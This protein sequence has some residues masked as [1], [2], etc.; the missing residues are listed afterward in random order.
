MKQ[1]IDVVVVCC[2]WR[3]NCKLILWKVKKYS[4]LLLKR[5]LWKWE[6]EK[7][8]IWDQQVF[9]VIIILVWSIFPVWLISFV[10]IVHKIN[11]MVMT[12]TIHSTKNSTM[13]KL[14]KLSFQSFHIAYTCTAISKEIRTLGCFLT[15]K[16]MK[17]LY[18]V[19]HLNLSAMQYLIVSGIATPITSTT[20][21]MNINKRKTRL[22]HFPSK[23]K[24]I[25]R[26]LKGTL[27][28]LITPNLPS[29]V[30]LKRQS[31]RVDFPIPVSPKYKNILY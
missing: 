9:K 7:Q 16:W 24:R 4:V 10:T 22:H 12:F 5:V 8:H 19:L 21:T 2:S 3:Y 14:K 23:L 11:L 17:R 26:N 6:N 25:P 20:T 30:V 1:T 13:Q 27:E 18:Q 28:H 29:N 31:I 15:H